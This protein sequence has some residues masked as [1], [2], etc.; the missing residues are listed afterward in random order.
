MDNKE[1]FIEIFT[2][3]IHRPGAAELLEWLESTDFFEA[4]AS[5]HYHGSYTGGLVEHSLNVY[6]ELI[7][8]GRV[9]GVPTAETYAVVALL[10]DI[11]RMWFLPMRTRSGKWT[12]RR[13]RLR[14]CARTTTINAPAPVT[15]K[16]A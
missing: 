10:H 7:G 15:R 11:A 12:T 16:P 1:R 6:Y 5:T 4:P 14:S 8:A 3:Q 2:S 9:P 13:W